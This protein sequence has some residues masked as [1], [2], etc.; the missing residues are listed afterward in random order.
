MRANAG[1][2]GLHSMAPGLMNDVTDKREL[3]KHYKSSSA[4]YNSIHSGYNLMGGSKHKDSSEPLQ[5]W[6]VDGLDK[7]SE[8]E[9]IVQAY[10]VI[11]PGPLS[12]PITAI[13]LEDGQ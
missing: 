3:S 1:N 13:T 2:N 7:Y 5:E 4:E 12:D 11:G 9:F 6:V 10:N 8:Y